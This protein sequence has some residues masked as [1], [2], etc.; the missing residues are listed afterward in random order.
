MPSGSLVPPLDCSLH[1]I[2]AS[3]FKKRMLSSTIGGFARRFL[4]NKKVAFLAIVGSIAKIR[5]DAVDDANDAKADDLMDFKALKRVEVLAGSTFPNRE[6]LDAATIVRLFRHNPYELRFA[7]AM[8]LD[9]GPTLAKSKRFR[10][11]LASAVSMMTG[12]KKVRFSGPPEMLSSK[13]KWGLVFP[14]AT[15]EVSVSTDGLSEET[16]YFSRTGAWPASVLVGV[17]AELGL[18]NREIVAAMGLNGDVI[19]DAHAK[20]RHLKEAKFTHT[21]NYNDSGS[22]PILALPLCWTKVDSTSH[23]DSRQ[24]R[25]ADSTVED[26]R[27]WTV[28]GMK[29]SVPY[30]A[31][32][33]MSGLQRLDCHGTGSISTRIFRRASS[34]E[35]LECDE[36]TGKFDDG[37][38]PIVCHRLKELA[39]RTASPVATSVIQEV[40]ETTRA[41][42]STGSY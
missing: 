5:A 30:S 33:R 39:V 36:M 2:H 37:Y 1:D 18:V 23:E 6:D 10:Q 28:C 3:S 19:V 21:R 24:Q 16:P 29:M 27:S 9:I 26:V 34:L 15:T 4:F 38:N 17:V 32:N 12:V 31:Y 13:H 41:K 8:T 25:F 42:F 20:C 7:T 14:V 11:D 35:H 40:V 22:K